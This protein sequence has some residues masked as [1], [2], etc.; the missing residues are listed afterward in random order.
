MTMMGVAFGLLWTYASRDRR[1]L[2]SD[3]SDAEPKR[4]HPP[5]PRSSPCRSSLPS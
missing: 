1:L 2:G 4:A 5:A 3:L